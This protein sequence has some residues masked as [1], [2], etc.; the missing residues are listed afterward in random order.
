M[1]WVE[2]TGRTVEDAKE[3]ALDELGVD[4]SDA[5][6]ELLEEPRAGLFG[7]LR[8]EARVRARVRPTAPRSKDDRRDRRRRGRGNAGAAGTETDV[9]AAGSAPTPAGA[10]GTGARGGAETTGGA[11]TA[12]RP[13]APGRAVDTVAPSPD[14]TSDAAAGSDGSGTGGESRPRRR[15]R[16]RNSA[17][18][19][20]RD[21]RSTADGQDHIIPNPTDVEVQEVEGAEKVEVP[22]DEQGRVAK[23]FLDRLTEEFGLRA[24]VKIVRPDEDTV[25][26]E[27]EGSDLGLLIGPK[28]ST[29]LAIQ[30]LTRTAVV[31]RTGANNGR[32]HVDVGGYRRKRTEAL[33]RFAQQVAAGVQESGA[34]TVLEPMSAADRKVVHDA[35]NGIE[36]V[37]TLSEGEEPRRRVVVVPADH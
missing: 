15:R 16:G 30:D 23:E 36:G 26:L 4:E 34:R 27:L 17:S 2:T 22:L 1:E 10:E 29:L 33:V 24:S 25:D 6:F 8:S 37:S 14:A 3:A 13:S 7:R 12:A 28:G 11:G 32:I 18:G 5:E 20:S 19:P 21:E 31:H 35:I 9:P